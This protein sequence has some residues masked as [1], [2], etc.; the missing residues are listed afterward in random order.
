MNTSFYIYDPKNNQQP[1]L[2]V[3]TT[4]VERYLSLI[5]ASAGLLL[6]IPSGLPGKRFRVSF[7][8]GDQPRA[9]YLGR[10]KTVDEFTAIVGKIPLF[11]DYDAIKNATAIGLADLTEKL[12]ILKL[13][14][15]AASKAKA[16]V[17]R[18]K[19]RQEKL[20]RSMV[21]AQKL[22]GLKT[23]EESPALDPELPPRFSPEGGTVLL[24]I[25]VE[26]MEN[27]SSVVT[28]I[29]LSILDTNDIASIS[30]GKKGMNWFPLIKSRHLR[31]QE[32]RYFV[33]HKYVRG[34]P[35]LFDFG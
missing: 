24:S 2:L 6:T 30:P 29:G 32:Y 10:S 31:V 18:A 11:G 16:A 33:N 21:E 4:Q 9:R 8:I 15:N 3:P 5:N 12:S 14:D 25:D 26:L 35:D 1:I 34:C 22:L 27:N 13:A 7:D 23:D 20:A 28:E 17:Q 19:E